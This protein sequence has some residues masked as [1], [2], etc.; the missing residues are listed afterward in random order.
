MLVGVEGQF[1]LVLLELVE[2]LV[3]QGQVYF[4]H[5]VAQGDRL[6]AAH[7]EYALYLSD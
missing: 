4:G 7:E 5:L 1:G 6:E 2:G 3:E